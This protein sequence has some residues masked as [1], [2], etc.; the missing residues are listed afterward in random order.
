MRR[1]LFQRLRHWGLT[2][3]LLLL[4]GFFEAQAEET[5]EKYYYQQGSER[6]GPI[7][8]EKLLEAVIEGEID[9]QTYVWSKSLKRW[10][11]LKD[12]GLIKK[13][14]RP[15][16]DEDSDEP[17]ELEAPRKRRRSRRATASF[18]EDS[19]YGYVRPFGGL[20]VMGLTSSSSESGF[21]FGAEV[22][23]SFDGTD[24]GV[25]YSRASI[26]ES[27]YDWTYGYIDA[28]LTQSNVLLSIVSQ[29]SFFLYGSRIGVSWYSAGLGASGESVSVSSSA[30]FCVGA[31]LG[32]RIPLGQERITLDLEVSTPATFE[33]SFNLN[34]MGMAAL[35]IGF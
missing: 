18:D 25:H 6:V 27:L 32:A 33:E 4:L 2:G 31:V 35:K 12:S 3:G 1:Q 21:G 7:P 22:G 17:P 26:S 34:L 11:R 9:E 28:T 19:S 5:G 14:R 29:T 16:S 8:R 13:S 10:K 15:A 30:L 20:N 24:L 23:Y